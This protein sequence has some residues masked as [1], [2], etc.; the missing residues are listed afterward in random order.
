MMGIM[1]DPSLVKPVLLESIDAHVPAREGLSVSADFTAWM[2]SEQRRVYGL[3]QHMLQDRD[4][5]DSATQD[6]F[7]KAHR[8]LQRIG[9]EDPAEPAKWLT[10]IAVN[11]CL[12]RLR[13]RRWQFW[14]KRAQTAVDQEALH[15]TV[16]GAPEAEDHYFAAQIRQR[17]SDALGQLSDRQRAVFTLRHYQNFT[18]DEIAVA[19]NLDSGTVKS[20]MHRAVTKLRVELRDLYGARP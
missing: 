2:I 13:S 14:R 9:A 4:E 3:C 16:S 6:T 5:A 8:A 11:T 10:R 15:R 20:H 1:A 18:M 19:L 7:L 17:L 12:D